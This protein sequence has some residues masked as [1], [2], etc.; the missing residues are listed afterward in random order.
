MRVECV[1]VMVVL[2]LNLQHHARRTVTLT[3]P[4]LIMLVIISK[5]DASTFLLE[6]AATTASGK[7]MFATSIEV[8]RTLRTPDQ[9]L[10]A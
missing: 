3:I 2:A 7:F 4:H 5:V 9:S 6:T 10:Y 1:L 8:T